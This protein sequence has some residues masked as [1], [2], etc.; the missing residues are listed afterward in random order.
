VSSYGERRIEPEA[1][2]LFPPIGSN[3]L[4]EPVFLLLRFSSLGS[5]PKSWPR[6]I[7]LLLSNTK[8]KV[9]NYLDSPEDRKAYAQDT[10]K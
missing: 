8:H 6:L 7:L 4:L 3:D 1:E 2:R 10:A 5:P 9:V